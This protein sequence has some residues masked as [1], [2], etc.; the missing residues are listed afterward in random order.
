[1]VTVCPASTPDVL[2]ESVSAAPFSAALIT[3]SLVMLFYADGD[4]GEI[5][6]QRMGNAGLRS[7]TVRAANGNI[8]RSAGQLLTSV[9]GTP[10]LQLPFASTVAA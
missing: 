3:S 4:G 1:M 10:T 2:P 7:G 8:Q 9:A 5:N 6:G